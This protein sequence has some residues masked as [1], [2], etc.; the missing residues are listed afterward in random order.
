MHGKMQGK[1]GEKS[2]TVRSRK[3]T[4][5]KLEQF[6]A[7]TAHPYAGRKYAQRLHAQGRSA[8]STLE[9]KQQSR[10]RDCSLRARRDRAGR[11]VAEC[12]R[13]EQGRT[14]RRHT[15][16]ARRRGWRRR[17]AAATM[18]AGPDNG[19]AHTLRGH[20]TATHASAAQ[21]HAVV[22]LHAQAAGAATWHA[23]AAAALRVAAAAWGL[24]TGLQNA[25]PRAMRRGATARDETSA[26]ARR[27]ATASTGHALRA[28]P[29]PPPCPPRRRPQ[30]H[31]FSAISPITLGLQWKLS[32]T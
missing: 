23:Q 26:P 30:R 16:R 18:H 13:A 22:A 1:Q 19:A 9:A 2:P 32:P 14:W 25:A 6:R 3:G 31:L 24:R 11:P 28:L 12:G 8:S 21:A 7:C 4:T 17:A 29:P 10:Y 27:A 20:S 15:G 5:R